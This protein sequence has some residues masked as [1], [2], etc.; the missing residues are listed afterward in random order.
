MNV[1]PLLS[2]A[3]LICSASRAHA[4]I[5]SQFALSPSPCAHGGFATGTTAQV[6][7]G[8]IVQLGR[9]VRVTHL[10]KL[11][12]LP[13]DTNH[14]NVSLWKLGGVP[15]MLA[16]ATPG[17][18]PLVSGFC[19]FNS[20]DLAEMLTA[21]VEP[22]VLMPGDYEV[23]DD[24]GIGYTP[25]IWLFITSQVGLGDG[26]TLVGSQVG[27]AP[28]Q[29]AMDTTATF[30]PSFAFEPLD[31]ALTTT[32]VVPIGG[33]LEIDNFSAVGGV[34]QTWVSPNAA[35][36]SLP[37]YGTL[38]IGPVPVFQILNT[39]PYPTQPGFHSAALVVPNDA[40][41]QGVTLHFQSV[42]ISGTLSPTI[43]LSN[44]S[45]TQIQ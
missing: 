25:P 43:T 42:A 35:V 1:H 4:Q 8:N 40:T 24:H 34:F 16:S 23:N 38:L 10:C 5:S 29:G 33:T 21:S 30:G 31:I 41:L 39:T 13:Q 36:V 15:T 22:L 26:V 9:A 7:W 27:S 45:A 11:R 18:D 28:S 44:S 20:S 19:L 2:S 14:P 37:P 12:V 32:K 3:I 6:N 17:S